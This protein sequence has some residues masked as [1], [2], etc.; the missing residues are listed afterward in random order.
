VADLVNAVLSE[1]DA[2]RDEQY[3]RAERLLRA[4]MHPE[5]RALDSAAGNDPDR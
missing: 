5:D 1:I 4:G 2:Q 3:R